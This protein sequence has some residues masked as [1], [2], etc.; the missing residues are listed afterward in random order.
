MR[1]IASWTLDPSPVYLTQEKLAN[2]LNISRTSVTS[3]LSSFSERGY[4]E[5]KYRAIA[6]RDAGGLRNVVD[7]EE[8]RTRLGRAPANRSSRH[9]RRS[10]PQKIQPADVAVDRRS[11]RLG[12]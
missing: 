8:L 5:V 7:S 2:I 1:N 3:I 9:S 12:H 4:I 11:R 10:F 6:V